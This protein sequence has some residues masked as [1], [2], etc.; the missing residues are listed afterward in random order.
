[1]QEKAKVPLNL[2]LLCEEANGT[3]VD[4]VSSSRLG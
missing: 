2:L 4:K 1:M 3:S